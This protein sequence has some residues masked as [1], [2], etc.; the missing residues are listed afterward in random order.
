MVTS[1]LSLMVFLLQVLAFGLGD[2][3]MVSKVVLL[4]ETLEDAETLIKSLENLVA[5][6]SESE[7]TQ[8]ACSKSVGVAVTLKTA[9]QSLVANAYRSIFCGR[10]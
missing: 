7:Q 4:G 1:S 9:K 5:T 6:L 8:D 3:I 2:G 10:N